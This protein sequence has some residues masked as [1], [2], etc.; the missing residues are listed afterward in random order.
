MIRF[1]DTDMF[2]AKEVLGDH[3]SLMGSVPMNL[4]QT[5][6][7]SEVE[8]Y[9]KKLIQICGKGGGYILRTCT[10]YIQEAKIENIKAMMDTVKK[11]GVY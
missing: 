2:K 1:T 6:S 4:L 8:E 10:D 9:C 7:P 5:G 11:Y 3:V